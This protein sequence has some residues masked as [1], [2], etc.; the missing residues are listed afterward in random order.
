M[1]NEVCWAFSHIVPF[2]Q[3][4]HNGVSLAESLHT[5]LTSLLKEEKSW[6]ALLGSLDVTRTWRQMFWLQYA[7][8]WCLAQDTI[9]FSQIFMALLML[10]F[11]MAE[12]TRYSAYCIPL[13]DLEDIW[14]VQNDLEPQLQRA[15][16]ST[17]SWTHYFLICFPSLADCLNI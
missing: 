12:I 10:F 15:D 1:P 16:V 6:L 11:F 5:L 9:F 17:H 13:Q 4:L 2:S 3:G 14:T 7:V 8:F